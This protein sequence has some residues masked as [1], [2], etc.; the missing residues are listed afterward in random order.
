MIESIEFKNFKVLRD[1][2]LPLSRCNVLVGPNGSGKSTVLQALQGIRD[3]KDL[4]FARI[5]SLTSLSDLVEVA[6]NLGEAESGIACVARW[7]RSGDHIYWY[8]KGA[9]DARPPAGWSYAQI[10]VLIRAF[11]FDPRAIARPAT[12]RPNA[13]LAEDGGNL[14]A[15]LDDI[16]DTDPE[17]FSAINCAL[18]QWLPEFK[19]I[20]FAQPE[21]GSKSVVLQTRKE[22]V[23]VPANDLSQGTLIAL[24][25]L[26]LAYLPKPPSLIGIEE[27]DRGVHPR[28]LRLV[29]DAI[30]RLCYPESC[31]ETREPVQVIVTTHSPYFLDL[32]KDH[33]EEVVIANRVGM[34]AKFERLSDRSDIDEILSGVSLGEIWYSGI[35]G[36]VPDESGV[37]SEP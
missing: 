15:V 12:V 21:P 22:G 18:G 33:P 23:S 11:A 36:G 10:G 3:P 19:S 29:Q 9:G 24:A 34:E 32:F 1:A 25:M 20:L 35:L 13:E 27:P 28:L 30:Y 17:R 2:K 31:G 6:L 4:A 26:T 5:R 37:P 16:R 14:A 7:A 8:R